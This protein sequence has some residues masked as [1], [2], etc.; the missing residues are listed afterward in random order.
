MESYAAGAADSMIGTADLALPGTLP[1]FG[2]P[3]HD[4][5]YRYSDDIGALVGPQI[6]IGGEIGGAAK[7]VAYAGEV[8][9]AGLSAASRSALAAVTGGAGAAGV[10]ENT[11]A[12]GATAAERALASLPRAARESP[13]PPG[14]N[15][16]T[17]EWR[18]GSRANVPRSWWDPNGVE[19]RFHPEDRWHDP[20][21]DVNPWE[22]WNTSWQHLYPEG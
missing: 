15:P 3:D 6:L 4:S 18:E 2:N 16:A 22:E 13:K 5:I 21:W 8:A 17:W 10:A 7:G 1:R 9:E 20:H 12:A 19:W 14:W 11:A